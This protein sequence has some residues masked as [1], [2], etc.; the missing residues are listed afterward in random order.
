M[1]GVG[2]GPHMYSD[3][4]D[5]DVLGGGRAGTAGGCGNC[6]GALGAGRRRGGDDGGGGGDD[7]VWACGIQL[8]MSSLPEAVESVRRGVD[9]P[10]GRPLIT[11]FRGQRTSSAG[12]RSA[13][14]ASSW[15]QY[16]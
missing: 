11:F 7:G 4:D 10:S 3:D 6:A 13:V 15:A 5:A 8:D 1:C 9:N 14:C 2:R 16:R 12:S